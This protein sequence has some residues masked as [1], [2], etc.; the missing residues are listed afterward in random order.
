M[1]PRLSLVEEDRLEATILAESIRHRADAARLA[2]LGML[3]SIGP[4][5]FVLRER[6]P[7]SALALWI[8]PLL[9]MLVWRAV[10]SYR[11]R[12]AIARR[13]PSA[14]TTLDDQFRRLSLAMQFWVGTG[15]WSVAGHG[16]DVDL[17]V[18]LAVCVFGFGAAGS[19]GHDAR[20]VMLS[21]PL[22]FGQAIAFWLLK[23]S[24]GYQVSV[25]LIAVMVLIIALA[26]RAEQTFRES[27]AIRFEND[28]LLRDLEAQKESAFA[29]A[30]TADE[31]NRS[32]SM[33]LAAASHDLR[34]PLY[35]ISLLADALSHHDL[36]GP[37][38]TVVAQQGR[39]LEALRHMFDNLL[40]LSR[41]DS[42]DVATNVDSIF[43]PDLLMDLE[44]EFAPLFEARK[45]P[46]EIH[47][48]DVWV[49]TD[50]DLLGRLLRNLV[51]NAL[52]YTER[53]HVAI[54]VEPV[55]GAIRL[56]VIDT[57]RGIDP[58]DHE[59][60]FQEFVQLDNP[61]R[62]RE[63]G[64]GLGL[65]IVKRIADLLG[66]DLAVAS[67]PGQGTQMILTLP[68]C[69]APTDRAHAIAASTP[70][71]PVP[72]PDL[73]LWIVENDDLVRD[74]L[75]VHF[76]A[77]S[78]R[79][80]F[81]ESRGELEALGARSGWPDFAIL[82]DMLG[83][84]ETGLDLARWLAQ[85]LPAERILLVTGNAETERSKILE[86]SGF[87]L[88]LKPVSGADLDRW[89]SASDLAMPASDGAQRIP[90]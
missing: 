39:A 65:S 47:C 4:F 8:L 1:S 20:T 59:R 82:D 60:I 52:R 57:G 23:G 62:T 12:P 87:K 15:V 7:G 5:Y 36:P 73:Y 38:R 84:D 43:L 16:G 64:V 26:R 37:T 68:A 72:R 19:L 9:P 24:Q 44:R 61:A 3:I 71:A 13:D 17:Y 66:H 21:M 74:A 75:G 18:T 42:G 69:A 33:F 58:A 40:D 32:K 78:I 83:G 29:A 70:G 2:V 41:F 90:S 86:E 80:D 14:L 85:E 79:Y 35:A 45:L 63:K 6:I 27:I 22:L 67:T 88:L 31:A 28:A 89:L 48:P 51:G 50:Y 81:A 49:R 46:L 54:E 30:R 76:E 53:G 34:Q 11:A 56:T 77:R 25:P 55:D 10:L